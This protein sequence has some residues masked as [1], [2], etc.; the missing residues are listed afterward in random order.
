MSPRPRQ[1]PTFTLV[2]EHAGR[3]ADGTPIT[4]FHLD[5]YRLSDEAD[6][7]SFGYDQYLAPVDGITLIEWPE[8]AGNWLPD[9]YVLIEMEPVGMDRRAI[10]VSVFP[11]GS[12]LATR[13]ASAS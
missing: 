11:D 8:R 9:A 13:I 2:A 1:S 4:L 6:L 5:L 12:D 3:T 7:E 10:R